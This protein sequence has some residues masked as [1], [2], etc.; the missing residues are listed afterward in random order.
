MNRES[1]HTSASAAVAVESAAD[2]EESA[3]RS[4]LGRWRWIVV[5]LGIGL[6]AFQLF[7]AFRGPYVA[8]IQGPVHVGSALALIY[9]LHPFGRRGAEKPGIPWWDV[10]LAAAALFSN[11]YI[12]VSYDRL[13]TRAVVMGYTTMDIV[14]AALGV[15]L[16]L[17]ATR[18]AVGLP[19]VVVATAAMAYGVLGPWIPGRL[20]H[21]GFDLERLVTD[22]TLTTTA[23]YGTAIQVSSTFIFL[24][25][26]FGVILVNSGIGRWL[27][28]LAFSLTGTMTGGTAKAA[29]VS[30]ALQGTISGSSV[31]NTVS[32]GSFT[33]PMMKRAGF[34]KE[35][36][37]ATE[38]AA[39]TGGQFMPPVM[40]A[41]AFIM[42][43][44][45]GIAYDQIIIMAA[46]P[47]LL[48]FTGVFFS[49]HWQAARLGILGIPRAHLPAAGSLLRRS[50]L[51]API[52]V[53]IGTLMSGRTPMMAAL[54]GLGTALFVSF[55]SSEGRQMLTRLWDIALEGAKWALPVIAACA[56]AGIVAGI[57][58]RTGLGTKLASVLTSMAGDNLY[59]LLFLTMVACLILGMGLPTTANYIV[60]ATIAAPALIEFGVPA[61]AAHLFVFYFGVLADITP[62][63]CLAAYAAA[64]IARA[65]P[66]KVGLTAVKIA[67]AAFIVPYLFVMNPVLVLQDV[68]AI[69]LTVALITAIV[70]MV[71]IAAGLMGYLIC[72]SKPWESIIL[73]VGGL[74]LAI[75]DVRFL[76]PG[77]VLTGVVIVLQWIR[78][79]QPG[80]RP[81][82]MHNDFSV[83][84]DEDDTQRSSET[85]EELRDEESTR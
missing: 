67:I 19:I 37:G 23:I 21:R 14:V 85:M 4:D 82:P 20:G 12:V 25:L 41:A 40:G 50:Y 28:D 84:A 53:L 33:I 7:T 71:I 64:G 32:S 61:I 52:V 55:F 72:I 36:A 8:L 79:G 38:A 16:L 30:S 73:F 29:V 26:L 70:G 77:I 49:T 59:L 24:F 3:R 81:E 17:E 68:T 63:V 78:R 42:A 46:I 31:A 27:D 2:P 48:Y 39:S 22:M 34:K 45:T 54:W 6:T 60:T 65:N 43:A 15:L 18:R 76:L 69:D 44:Y 80:A 56:T 83:S 13:V 51:V 47:A 11:F 66:F 74:G 5:T 10:L 58:T 62:P 1:T 75:P 57:V 9:L 35:F